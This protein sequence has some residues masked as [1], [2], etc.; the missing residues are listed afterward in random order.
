M[1]KPVRVYMFQPRFAPLVEDGVKGQT[2]RP[3][4]RHP[5]RVGDRLSLR[6]W[7]GRPYASKQRSLRETCCRRMARV[8][9]AR[10]RGVWLD[11]QRLSAAEI[12]TFARLDGFQEAAEMFGWF[13]ATHG[14]P[15]RGEV[16]YWPLP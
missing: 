10:N 14:L 12:E 5:T 8:T 16:T 9:F 3:R 13:V 6:E 11:G 7:T 2:V 4:R 1:K 15:F